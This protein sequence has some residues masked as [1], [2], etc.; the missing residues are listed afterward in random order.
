MD[1]APREVA[2][3]RAASAFGLD[4]AECARGR[5]LQGAAEA[6]ACVEQRASAF[7]EHYEGASALSFSE[8]GDDRAFGRRVGGT[9]G[10]RA[11]AE[12][13]EHAVR[14]VYGEAER[15]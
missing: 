15:G 1:L 3:A 11:R 7:G 12:E 9:Y 8:P 14:P 10:P 5:V 4:Y 6:R 2:R 13:A